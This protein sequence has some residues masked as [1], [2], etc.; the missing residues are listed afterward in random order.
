MAAI[1]QEDRIPMSRDAGGIHP[2]HRDGFTPT[3][4]DAGQRADDL[5]EENVSVRAPCAPV[6]TSHGG[7]HHRG[8]TCHVDSLQ[9]PVRDKPDRSAVGRPEKPE[10]TLRPSQ[11][12]RAVGVERAQPDLLRPVGGRHERKCSA[13]GRKRKICDEV[14][15]SG[16]RNLHAH[17]RRVDRRATKIQRGRQGADRKRAKDRTKGWNPS[18]TPHPGRSPTRGLGRDR[19]AGFLEVERRV[20]DVT[21]TTR[22]ILREAA[23]QKPVDARRR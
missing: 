20:A 16:R 6:V 18:N 10:R 22:G 15:R 7:Q 17:L 12:P 14:V 5:R 1:G 4:R 3:R 8:S 9:L 23:V 19:F 11:R 13:V 2:R 21:K